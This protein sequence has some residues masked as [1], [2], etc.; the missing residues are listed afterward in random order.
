MLSIPDRNAKWLSQARD[1]FVRRL[2]PRNARRLGIGGY[3]QE[4]PRMVRGVINVVRRTTV[5]MTE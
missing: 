3:A 1:R 4:L 5:T 2:R